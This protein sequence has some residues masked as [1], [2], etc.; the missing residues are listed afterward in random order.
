MAWVDSIVEG[1]GVGVVLDREPTQ[2]RHGERAERIRALHDRYPNMG[3]SAIARRVGCDESN[4]RGVLERYA[5]GVA[6]EELRDYQANQA[7]IYDVMAHRALI[8]ITDAHLER[9]SGLQLMTMAAIATDKSRL[10]RG[11]ATSISVNALLDVAQLIREG[12]A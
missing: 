5:R 6:P 7:D 10:V 3:N 11:Q 12:K 8:S 9:A 1:I 2:P 4:V